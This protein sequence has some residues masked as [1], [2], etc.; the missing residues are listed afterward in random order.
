MNLIIMI[1]GGNGVSEDRTIAPVGQRKKRTLHVHRF[2]MSIHSDIRNHVFNKQCEK[3][4]S[5]DEIIVQSVNA[6]RR[7]VVL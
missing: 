1:E 4:I 5:Y 7:G 2:Y 3:A 6:A